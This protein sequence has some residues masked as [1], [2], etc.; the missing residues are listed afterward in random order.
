MEK[1]S[2]SNELSA[3]GRRSAAL[4][5]RPVLVLDGEPYA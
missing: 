3:Q 1:E 2:L 4:A 5:G